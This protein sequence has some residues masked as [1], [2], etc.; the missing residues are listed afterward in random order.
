[1]EIVKISASAL[2][3]FLTCP[4]RYFWNRVKNIQP[5]ERPE[6]LDL[7]SA[8][9]CGL[10]YIYT[11][12]Q[13]E[14]TDK[15]II[16]QFAI[17]KVREYAEEHCMDD[18]ST[19]KAIAIVD[20]YID[21]EWDLLLNYEILCIETYFK[22]RLQP[23]TKELLDVLSLDKEFWIHGYFDAVVKDRQSGHILVIEHKTTG[24]MS[25]E[26]L[27]RSHIDY[28]VS[29]YAMACKEVFGKCDGIIYD[30]ISKPKHI[31]QTGETDEEF[32]LRKAAS[33]TG[34]IKRKE[35]ETKD[36]FI[37]RVEASFCDESFRQEF[38]PCD[39]EW[40]KDQTTDIEE[41]VRL[42]TLN[43][44]Y[45]KCPGNCLKYGA[46][47]YMDLCTRKVTLDNLG[48]KYINIVEANEVEK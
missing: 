37:S 2:D 7:G 44:L 16:R 47:P 13:N 43:K 6:A 29:I 40:L 31:M 12:L 20:C 38:I 24:M 39:E 21:S 46:C 9:H 23:F 34:R 22:F 41:V 48:D 3:E 35:A 17:D 4:K 10:A 1:M 5:V 8:V 15:E 18:E 25:D 36:Q 42:M 19:C 28:Q 26:Y 32:D 33:K 45:H 14:Q 30:A 27:Q 11:S